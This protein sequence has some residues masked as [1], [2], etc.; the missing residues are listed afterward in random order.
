M[1]KYTLLFL[2][3]CL[4]AINPLTAQKKGRITEVI[5]LHTNDMHA[6]IDNMA[7]LAYLADSLKKTRKYVF[8]V[9]AGDN[10]T[11]NPVVD[12]VEDKGY[13][14]IDLMN[15]C[16]FNLS[17]IGNHE[18]DL[19]QEKLNARIKQA[20]FPFISCNIDAS[21]AILKQP[22]PFTILKAGRLKIPVLGIIQL[23]ENGL[24]DSHPDKMKG[25]AFSNGLEKAKEYK[26]L[27]NKYGKL[28][29]LTHLGVDDDKK[30]ARVMPELDLIIGGHSH[31]VLN[32]PVMIDSVM[33]IQAGSGLK[34]AGKATL[35]F[36][37]GKIVER[38][39][40]L[41]PLN[42]I[43]G[44]QPE[45]KMLIDKY[46]DNKELNRSI[47]EATESING[48]DELGS[49]MT[50][51]VTATLN[52]DFA[53]Q[54]NG[55]IRIPSILKGN[56]TLKDVYKLDPFGNQVVTYKMNL[57]EIKSLIVNSFNRNKEIDLQVSGMTYEV[58]TDSKGSFKDL[59][60][61]DIQGQ[62]LETGKIYTV[63]INSYMAAA[64]KF[65]HKD[66]GIAS[67]DT[68]AQMLIEYLGKKQKVNYSGVKRVSMRSEQ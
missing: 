4:V 49:L 14:L 18:F 20:L 63:A 37:K 34:Y 65:D 47:A 52:T 64:Y 17:A 38:K 3:I 55:G 68:T 8:L 12:M 42:S 21:Q 29:A 36:R 2:A 10:F 62:P 60:M 32:E 44:E 46:N 56:I 54:N 27:K 45:V 33:I 57:N 19:G 67:Y 48:Y 9:A 59:R 1:K 53:F 28:I 51:A 13:P 5:I 24:P 50:D 15:R 26:W 43:P 7:K 41:I 40:E 25:V 66:E 23:G 31:T 35:L 30:L 6:R 58:I 39:A 11:G 61:T 16:G 22:E